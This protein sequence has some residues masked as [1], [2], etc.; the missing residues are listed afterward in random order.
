[1]TAEWPLTLPASP[2]AESYAETAPD[3]V[4]RSAA[5]QGPA[6]LRRRTTA[7]VRN[8]RLA[9]VLSAGQTEIL[10]GFYLADLKGGTLPFQQAHPRTGDAAVMRFK[11]PPD[12]ASLNGGY[13]RVTLELEIL[14]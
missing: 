13:F 10:D 12:Y 6:K 5:D 14:P 1:M 4:I 11:A 9:Y 7:A 2:L 8:L 3:N